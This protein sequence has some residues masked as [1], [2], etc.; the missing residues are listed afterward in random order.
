MPTESVRVPG[1]ALTYTQNLAVLSVGNTNTDG[2][3]G[4]YVTLRTAG[5]YGTVIESVEVFAPGTV[6]NG[7][8][9]FFVTD[10][11]TTIAIYEIVVPATTP[12]ATVSGFR[13]TW[14][15]GGAGGSL[16]IGMRLLPG[17]VLKAAPTNSESFNLTVKGWDY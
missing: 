2:T 4:T 9:R 17:W 5:T 14:F 13:Q 10:G 11:T 12:S 16:P 15:P 1:S 6:T 7:K 8:I 3:T